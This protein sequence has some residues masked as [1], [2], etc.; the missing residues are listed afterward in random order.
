MQFSHHSTQLR[1]NARER[2]LLRLRNNSGDG[3]LDRIARSL[4][5]R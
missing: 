3:L 2:D 5:K 1:Y 4:R